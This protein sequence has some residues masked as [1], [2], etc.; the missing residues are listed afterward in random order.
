M[1]FVALRASLVIKEL[2]TVCFGALLGHL[3]AF[4]GKRCKIGAFGAFN[5]VLGHYIYI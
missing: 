2:H 5:K 3:V 1:A 4:G